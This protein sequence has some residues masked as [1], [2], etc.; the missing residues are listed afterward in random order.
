M[1]LASLDFYDTIPAPPSF[2]NPTASSTGA[3]HRSSTVTPPPPP[4]DHHD[5]HHHGTHLTPQYFHYRSDERL[6]ERTMKK[7]GFASNKNDT[8]SCNNKKKGKRVSLHPTVTVHIVLHYKD[9]TPSEIEKTW[10]R[11]HE[12]KS[13]RA[14]YRDLLCNRPHAAGE[15]GATMAHRSGNNKPMI[16]WIGNANNTMMDAADSECLRGLEGKTLEGHDRKTQIRRFARNAV[17]WEQGRQRHMGFHDEDLLADYY[18][19]CSEGAQVAA[20][21][22]GLR[23]E[24]EAAK[25]IMSTASGHDDDDMDVDVLTTATS[26]SKTTSSTRSKKRPKVSRFS[27]SSSSGLADDINDENMIPTSPIHVDGKNM[28]RNN[29]SSRFADAGRSSNN[30]KSLLSLSSYTVCQPWP[31]RMNQ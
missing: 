21:L 9:Y 18:F 2:A 26:S 22:L 8:P 10:Y 6:G 16:D 29:N 11:K 27:F 25:C 23:D 19:E 4:R 20:Y 28:V 3:P 15:Y 1:T 31:S 17:L 5:H 13:I 12:L 14:V 30:M 7:S 24:Q